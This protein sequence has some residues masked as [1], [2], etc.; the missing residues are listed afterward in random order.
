MDRGGTDLLPALNDDLK[1]HI[2]AECDIVIGTRD[3]QNLPHLSRVWGPRLHLDE[4]TVELFVDLPKSTDVLR[5]LR[6][7]GRVAVTAVHP[8]TNRAIQMKG[9]CIEI[10]DPS[11]D[12]WTWIDRHRGGFAELV[13]NFGYPAHLVRNMWSV[14]VKK[15]RIS[16]EA[17]FDQTPGPGAGKP[18]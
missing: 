18:L 16:I 9:R 11:G 1:Q 6:D 10:G 13:K 14:Q 5:D 7:N 15:L 4:G 12:D 17:A 2:E 8:L 3:A